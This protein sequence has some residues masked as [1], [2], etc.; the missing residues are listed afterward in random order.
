MCA[1]IGLRRR[2]P[3]RTHGG[4]PLAIARDGAVAVIEPRDQFA[5]ELAG[6]AAFAEAE[7]RPRPTV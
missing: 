3:G 5:R 7:E 2:G 1:E 6:A 4:K